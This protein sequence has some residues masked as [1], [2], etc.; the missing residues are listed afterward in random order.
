MFSK[1]LYHISRRS[2]KIQSKTN[3]I[4][5]LVNLISRY[6]LTLREFLFRDVNNQLP[7]NL[8]K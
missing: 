2:L 3:S 8:R 1:N 5:L 6:N 7:S 4:N